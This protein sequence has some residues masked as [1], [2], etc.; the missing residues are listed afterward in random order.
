MDEGGSE[1]VARQ[2]ERLR[3]RLAAGAPGAAHQ[4]EMAPGHRPPPVETA[5]RAARGRPSAA[6]VLLYPWDGEAA[7]VLTVRAPGLRAHAGQVSLPGG[8]LEPGETHAEAA[9]REAEEELGV[10]AGDLEVLGALSPLWIPP[11][12]FTVHPIVAATAGRPRFVPA[13]GEVAAV[14]EVPLGRLGRPETRRVARWTVRGQPSDIPH[15]DV[16]GHVVWGATA[17]ILAELLAAWRDA[18][19]P[20]AG[21]GR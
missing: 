6:L 7:T 2:L 13:P 11:T 16:G 14:L 12:D 19:P 9:L 18:A 8:R 15:F 1:R 5:A 21:A 3:A 20:G 17:M 4:H 10:R